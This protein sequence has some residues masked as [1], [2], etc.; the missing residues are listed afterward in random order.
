MAAAKSSCRERACRRRPATSPSARRT[1]PSPRPARLQAASGGAR[2]SSGRP[3]SPRSVRMLAGALVAGQ[4][5]GAVVGVEER[6][7]APSTRATMRTR[8][9]SPPSANT[10]STRSWRMPCSRSAP[11]GGRR[12]TRSSSS[13]RTALRASPRRAPR[14]ARAVSS[15]RPSSVD[16]GAVAAVLQ[17]DPDHAERGAAQ[18]RRDPCEPVGFSSMAKKPTRCPA[19]RP[20]RPRRRPAPRARRR[21]G[22]SGR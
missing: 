13:D 1:A 5:V 6:V 19:C 11:S 22:P 14:W 2:R 21:S 15:A 17:H 10:A 3:S 9:S 8:S 12:R 7:A 16:A 18:A 4:Q 20:A